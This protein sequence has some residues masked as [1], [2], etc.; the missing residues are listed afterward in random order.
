MVVNKSTRV[1]NTELNYLTLCERF[2]VTRRKKFYL[3]LTLD[4][5]NS[6]IITE[7]LRYDYNSNEIN[8]WKQKSRWELKMSE[9][10]DMRNMR[11]F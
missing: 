4:E 5:K 8:D 2:F 9:I 10:I 3:K 6:V 11:N 7:A 1:P